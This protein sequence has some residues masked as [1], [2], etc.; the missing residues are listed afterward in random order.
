M[1]S[2]ESSGAPMK[3]E[4]P[5]SVFVAFDDL[6]ARQRATAVC[7][8]ITAK[9]WPKIDFEVQWCALDQ[10][11]TPES[12]HATSECATKAQIVIIASS[13]REELPL[14]AMQWLDEWCRCRHGREGALI[15]L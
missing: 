10:L 2:L 8:S 9:S 7:D 1:L 3:A 11:G 13:A 14:K 4:R 15:G 6:T 12:A 5:W